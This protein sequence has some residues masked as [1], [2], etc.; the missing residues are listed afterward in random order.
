[1][2]KS[3]NRFKM[4]ILFLL[5]WSLLILVLTVYDLYTI[6]EEIQN[7]AMNEARASFKR[8]LA[9]R[10][11]ASSHGG[12]YV[13]I[14]S[15]TTPNPG[16]SHIPE[17][18]INTPSGKE[19]TLMN[20]A[21]MMRQIHE[22]YLDSI[23]AKGKITS[24]K[25]IRKENEPDDWEIMA[26]D[27]FEHGLVEVSEYVDINNKPYLRYM[28]ALITQESCLKCHAFQ[29][30]KVGDIRGGV[31]VSVPMTSYL[32]QSYHHQ[33]RSIITYLSI[34]L[35]GAIGIYFSYIKISNSLNKIEHTK[36]L[37]SKQNQSLNIINK[38]FQGFEEIIHYPANSINDL[39]EFTL[40][41]LMDYTGSEYGA[42][43]HYDNDKKILFLNNYNENFQLVI[44]KESKIN[45]EN[46]LQKAADEKAPIIINSP[47]TYTFTNKLNNGI[48]SLTIPVI[49][50]NN[51][52]A[53]FWLGNNKN[54]FKKHH[55]KQGMLLLDTAWILVEKMKH[56][57]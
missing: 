42:V 47:S 7:L 32:K 45:V 10:T 18:D 53:L 54:D 4:L 26:L 43:Y 30:Y 23:G 27:S 15:T 16:L 36:Q 5:G 28:Q 55:A 14:D 35:L 13:F 20:P 11:W 33:K 40:N 1:M 8:D 41:K 2:N 48:K 39:L 24:K 19:L 38:R 17:R 52:V 56:N 21:Y 3:I 34:W 49:S 31:G 29:G 6:K 37:L 12:V 50:N 22:L 46:C 9:Y 25:L 57:H 44:N 51:V